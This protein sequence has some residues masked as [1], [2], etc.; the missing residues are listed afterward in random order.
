MARRPRGG[1]AAGAIGRSYGEFVLFRMKG[2]ARRAG[3]LACAMLLGLCP[4][5]GVF[6]ETSTDL[7][8]SRTE[9]VLGTECTITLYDHGESKTLDAC[10]DRLREIHARMTVDEPGSELDAVADAAGREPVSVT[11]DVFVVM[12]RALELSR[13]SNG[14]FDPTVGPLVKLWGVNTRNA[15]VPSAAEI[16]AARGLINWRDV[17]MDEA[18]KTIFLK[19]PGMMLDVGGVGKGYAAD[20][21]VRILSAHGVQSAMV[22]LGGNIFA[23]GSHPGG[24]PWKIGVQNPDA[25]RGSPF[26]IASVINKT[27]VTSGVYERFFMKNGKRY[28]HIMDIHTGEP[29]DN[30]V[31]SATVITDRSFDADGVTLIM[32]SLGPVEGVKLG[33]RLGLDVI[34]ADTD[35]RVYVTPRTKK[36]FAITDPEFTYA[37]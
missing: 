21:M 36:I 26:G 17:V 22:D 1:P 31:M 30:T 3:I 9:Q 13:L 5:R 23:M 20:E 14:I 11:D 15:R 2:N 7:P 25:P 24:A 28:H 34:M 18:A 19:R 32:L 33:E 29:V 6:A 10:F 27:V 4:I 8:L 37:D 35:H 16:A 12:K